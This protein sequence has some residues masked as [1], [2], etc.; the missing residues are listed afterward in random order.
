MPAIFNDVHVFDL[1]FAEWTSPSCIQVRLAIILPGV[2]MKLSIPPAPHPSIKKA[3][4]NLYLL[5][6]W[7][8]AKKIVGGGEEGEK[9]DSIH[10]YPCILHHH[11]TST[12]ILIS[13]IA[14]VLDHRTDVFISF[15]HR[16]LR[17]HHGV[18]TR[19]H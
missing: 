17:L 9:A 2:Y 4:K 7:G 11:R 3:P 5:K 14:E 1:T 16:A 13:T 6:S 15:H 12:Q 18:G 10:K 8:V 19:R